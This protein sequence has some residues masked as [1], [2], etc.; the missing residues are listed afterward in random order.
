M[1]RG[2][3]IFNQAKAAVNLSPQPFSLLI[4]DLDFKISQLSK[5][6]LKTLRSVGPS[7]LPRAA[8][9]YLRARQTLSN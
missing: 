4:Q 7:V 9:D 8:L 1:G 5:K 3:V 2:C 6:N